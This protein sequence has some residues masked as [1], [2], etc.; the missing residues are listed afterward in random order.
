MKGIFSHWIVFCLLIVASCR[1]PEIKNNSADPESAFIQGE[2]GYDLRFLRMQDSGL[3]VLK[4]GE[5]QVI[6]SPKFQAKVFT[7]TADGERGLSFG[8]INYRAFG[9]KPDAHMNAYGGENR[10]WLG[11]E[12]GKY[13]LFFAPGAKMIF[14]NWKTPAAFD[15]ESWILEKGDSTHVTMSKEINLLNYAGSRLNS[16]VTRSIVILGMSEIFKRT[17]IDGMDSCKTV[18]Y[19][20]LNG[21]TNTG[22]QPWTKTTGMPCIWILDMFTPSPQTVIIIPFRSKG[23]DFGKWATTNYFGE[24]PEDRIK[25]DSSV[26]FFKADGKSRGKLG[27]QAGHAREMAGSYDAEHRVLTVIQS[28]IFPEQPYLNQEWNT[29]KPSF[30]G[31]A[32]NAYND[33]PLANGSQMGP[34]YEMETVSPA[35]FLKPG[36]SIFQKHLVYHF[37]GSEKDLDKI[38]TRLLGVSL[39]RIKHIFP[40]EQIN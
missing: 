17:G 10:I 5:R 15:T 26:L 18:G 21:I 9:N 40:G 7:S 13:S 12:G 28:D 8:W 4:D 20:T 34:F 30:S 33:G 22:D 27:I 3:I 24:I 29:E 11:P 38:A 36:S 6:V 2:F 37:S 14:E 35:A 32:V 1:S 16:K 31:D 19:E 23:I 39:D 25:H